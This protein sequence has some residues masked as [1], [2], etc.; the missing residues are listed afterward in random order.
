MV[1]MEKESTNAIVKK[2]MDDTLSSGEI[3]SIVD[4]DML[5]EKG[6]EISDKDSVLM[7]ISNVNNFKKIKEIA[8]NNYKKIDNGSSRIVYL[9]SDKYVLKVAKNNKGLEQNKT[10]SIP[11][12]LEKYRDIV[13]N[14]IDFDKNGKWTVQQFAENI[15][16]DE[17]ENITGMQFRGFLYYLRHDLNWDGENAEFYNKIN[18]FI[19]EFELERFDVANGSSWG[20]INGKVV[21]R[22]Y[23]LSLAT[24]RKLYGVKYEK[25]GAFEKAYYHGTNA[26]I[27]SFR[28]DY[29]GKGEGSNMLGEGVYVA[30]TIKKAK[31]Y[32]KKIYIVELKSGAK[33]INYDSIKHEDGYDKFFRKYKGEWSEAKMAYARKHF[34]G[35][36]YGGTTVFIFNPSDL[37]IVGLKKGAMKDGGEIEKEELNLLAPNGKPSNLTPEQYKLVR[38]PQFIAWFGDWINSPETASKV[39]DENGEPLVVYHGTTKRFNVFKEEFK[40]RRFQTGYWFTSNKELADTYGKSKFYFINAKVLTDEIRDYYDESGFDAY[41][42]NYESWDE[43]L[44]KLIPHFNINVYKSVQIKLAD[45]TNTTFD[46]NNPDIRFKN[47]G[48]IDPHKEVSASVKSAIEDLLETYRYQDLTSMEAT[49]LYNKFKNYEELPNA[50]G[51]VGRNEYGEE[52]YSAEIKED[53][54]ESKIFE[55]LDDLDYV[56]YDKYYDVAIISQQGLA[57]IDA[58]R[59]RIE[60]RK[61]VKQGYDLFS[62]TANIKELKPKEKTAKELESDIKNLRDEIDMQIEVLN[63]LLGD[64]QQEK[65]TELVRQIE[66]QISF[67]VDLK[68][69]SQYSEG[70]SVMVTSKAE[71]LKQIEALK[72]RIKQHEKNIYE[73]GNKQNKKLIEMDNKHIE[74]IEGFLEKWGSELDKLDSA[75]KKKSSGYFE[76]ELSFL[77]W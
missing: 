62:E 16:E 30:K 69:E 32:G 50:E 22:D 70:G 55:K 59:A 34:D 6:G 72:D 15:S 31:E 4:S 43:N 64:A 35:V 8:D 36:E 40:D 75:I 66:D 10:E 29:Y 19:N 44:Q 33:L 11:K 42:Y 57:F 65:N 38:T 26:D 61:G 24:A 39:V 45:G 76:G 9:Y 21:L 60:T 5:M 18:D 58:V 12:I 23:G 68:S 28:A 51:K 53:G 14:V 49:M 52:E 71:H 46:D 67:L 77:N 20:K 3:D 47:G 37:K 41:V 1:V 25:G 7:N 13:A 54:L 17:F 73:S 74:K 48:E 27:S 56:S 2:D 63:D